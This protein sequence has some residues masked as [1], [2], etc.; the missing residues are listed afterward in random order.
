MKA[1]QSSIK[2]STP[3]KGEKKVQDGRTQVLTN[4]EYAKEGGP[5]REWEQIKHLKPPMPPLSPTHSYF[6]LPTNIN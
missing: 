4:E 1:C 5:L 6:S 3:T 2:Q